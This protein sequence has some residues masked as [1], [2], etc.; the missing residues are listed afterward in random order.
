MCLTSLYSFKN[1][2]YMMVTRYLKRCS[3]LL[4]IRDVQIK[5]IVSSHLTPVRMALIKK[6]QITNVSEDAEKKE[7]SYTCQWQCKLV[8]LL[9]KTV[10]RFLKKLKIELP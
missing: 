5:T 7:P 2:D 1:S 10:R 9:W 3:T 8:Q 4:M 6:N